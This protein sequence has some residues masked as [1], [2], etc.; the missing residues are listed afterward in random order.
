MSSGHHFKEKFKSKFN[1]EL[2]VSTFV[3]LVFAVSFLTLGACATESQVYRSDSQ[4]SEE[5][6]SVAVPRTEISAAAQEAARRE[7]EAEAARVKEQMEQERREEEAQ[8]LAAA[9]EEKAKQEAEAA[10][11]EQEA[12]RQR[13]RVEAAA[14]ELANQ[15]AAQQARVAELEAQIQANNTQADRTDELNRALR[16]AVE[17]AEALNQALSDE[18]AKYGDTDPESGITLQALDPDALD[19]LRQEKERLEAEVEALLA[20]ME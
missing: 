5:Q 3:R 20:E 19:M 8:A 4:V 7:A 16:R 17:S 12:R 6:G 1:M 18:Q 14:R 2:G 10:R 9:A 11:Q 15:Q 13:E